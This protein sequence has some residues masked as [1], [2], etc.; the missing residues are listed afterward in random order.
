MKDQRR[1]PYSRRILARAR[2]APTQRRRSAAPPTNSSTRRRRLGGGWPPS[3]FCF[4]E[5]GLGA[6]A[7]ARWEARGHPK[8]DGIERSGVSSGVALTRGESSRV[9]GPRR[10]SAVGQQRHPQTA[11]PAGAAWAAVGRRRHFVLLNSGWGL[12]RPRA[13][14]H[15][16]TQKQ[17]ALND[18]GFRDARPSSLSIGASAAPDQQQSDPLG[19]RPLVLAE[20]VRGERWSSGD[21]VAGR[22][23]TGSSPTRGIENQPCRAPVILVRA[24]SSC[25]RGAPSQRRRS[26]E[27]PTFRWSAERPAIRPTRWRRLGGASAISFLGR[28]M[29]LG[30]SRRTLVMSVTAGRP[31]AG[32]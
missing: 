29:E 10:P 12:A 32:S 31:R 16:D 21:R 28:T 25:A 5:F 20:S 11:R 1:C 24:E 22:S 6:G 17:T 26:A 9:R 7:A 4:I 8:T 15:G 3:P 14:R 30:R 19:R 13:G 18:Q 23:A 27:R 2:A